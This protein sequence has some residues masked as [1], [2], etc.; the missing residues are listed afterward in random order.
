MPNPTFPT[1]S[2]TDGS[3]R[4]ILLD[5]R[6][7]DAGSDGG[8][9]VRKLH[10]NK[11]AFELVLG[12]LNTTDQATLEAFVTANETASAI[13]YT[14]PEDGLVYVVR[15]GKDAVQRTWRP[16]SRRDYRIRLV[17]T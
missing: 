3:S 10:A 7:E 8:V 15:F 5:G 4:R 17:P 6:K 12:D 16:G 11:Y 1:I 9:R 14:W 2:R 13:D